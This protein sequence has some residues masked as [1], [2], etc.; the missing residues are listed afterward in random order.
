MSSLKKRRG[1]LPFRYVFL[2]SFIIFALLTI[3][4]VFF[5]E[6]GIRPTLITIANT[7]TQKIGTLAINQAVSKKTLEDFNTDKDMIDYIITENGKLVAV[8]FNSAKANK[9]LHDV[10]YSV[11]S[12]LNDLERGKVRNLSVPENVEIEREGL[13]ITENG[14]IYMMPLGQVTNNA[15]LAHLG[16]KVP[17]RFSIIGDV[18]SKF[19]YHAEELGINN[20]KL[21]ISVDIDVDV[22]I[23][24][25]FAT[26][27]NVVSTSLPLAMVLLQGDVPEFYSAGGEKGITP[28]V[29]DRSKNR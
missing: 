1:P 25:P 26:E 7:E 28:A 11:Q 5:V 14:I 21:T 13:S 27:T 9:F 10:N 17:V 2:T 16:P 18:K 29:I 6:K 23:V 8:E 20:T 12:Y 3:L 15:L 4:G 22:K 24:I 19:N